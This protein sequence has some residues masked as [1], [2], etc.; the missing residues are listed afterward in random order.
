MRDVVVT[1]S[2]QCARLVAQSLAQATCMPRS[3]PTR[4]APGFDRTSYEL[5]FAELVREIGD[6]ITNDDARAF[7]ER[8][9]IHFSYVQ[10]LLSLFVELGLAWKPRDGFWYALTRTDPHP[11]EDDVAFH[12]RLDMVDAYLLTRMSGRWGHV[13]GA[14]A[15]QM[16]GVCGRT[17]RDIPGLP[18]CIVTKTARFTT[19]RFARSE[20]GRRPTVERNL[21]GI[22]MGNRARHLMA[23][24]GMD[25]AVATRAEDRLRPVDYVRSGDVG[26]HL[27]QPAAAVVTMFEY[28][29]LSGGYAA[30]RDVVLHA[31]LRMG[32]EPICAEAATATLTVR[33]RLA[34]GLWDAVSRIARTTWWLDP[35]FPGSAWPIDEVKWWIARQLRVRGTGTRTLLDPHRRAKGRICRELGV[36][37]NRGAD[38]MVN[39]D[40]RFDPEAF[41]SWRGPIGRSSLG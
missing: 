32:F 40:P 14:W 20:A 22:D 9:G 23:G 30:Y 25:I 26:V 37:D 1:H 4:P 3:I 7:A 10:D 16:G 27:Q 8:N 38:P 36:V 24:C 33:R 35:C 29:R 18:F 17:S 13:A 41:G 31:V 21:N 39:T 6:V 12:R 28:P 5:V 34:F 19:E 11:D 15:L 2:W